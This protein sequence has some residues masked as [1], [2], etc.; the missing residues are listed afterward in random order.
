LPGILLIT[1]KHAK[2]KLK[3][4]KQLAFFLGVLCL[5]LTTL[6]ACSD[7][8]D[9]KDSVMI[10]QPTLTFEAVTD[11]VLQTTKVSADKEWSIRKNHENWITAQKSEGKFIVI[12]VSDNTG[13][14]A[15]EGK[16]VVE[17]GKAT[18]TLTVK[19]AAKK[20]E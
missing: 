20:A 11:G 1:L 17:C 5:G 13:T 6:S 4:F 16:V 14:G 3:P 12:G 7:D 19:Q 8:D 15:R 10:E 2:M 18:A 9:P